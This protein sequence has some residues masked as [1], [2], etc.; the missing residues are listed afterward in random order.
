MLCGG[1]DV[2][3]RRCCKVCAAVVLAVNA[4]Q[5][6]AVLGMGLSQC[7]SGALFG[8]LHVYMFLVDEQGTPLAGAVGRLP[9]EVLQGMCCTGA[10]C[11]CRT[12]PVP[13]VCAVKVIA[14]PKQQ[15]MCC[16]E[17]RTCHAES[18]HERCAVEVCICFCVCH[19]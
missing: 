10:G 15:G 3:Q 4:A 19:G 5:L 9:K 17:D 12:G 7:V 14:A 6:Y 8:G 16:V 13:L 11:E 1:W 2:C 18:A